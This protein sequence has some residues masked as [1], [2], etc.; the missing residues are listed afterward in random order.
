MTS[1]LKHLKKFNQHSG[2][3]DFTETVDFIL[4]NVSHCIVENDVHYNPEDVT[5]LIIT[6]TIANDQNIELYSARDVSAI[7]YFSDIEIDD[8]SVS[9]SDIDE[10]DGEYLLTKGVHVVKYTFKENVTII[11]DNVFNYNEN[12]TDIKIPNTV[13]SIGEYA[14]GYCEKITSLVIPD[15]VT[16]IDNTSF[17][18]CINLKYINVD[19]NNSIYDSRNNCSAIIETATNELIQGCQNTVIPNTVTSIGDYAFCGIGLTHI[20]IPN[21]VTNIGQYAFGYCEKI[22]SLVIPN[23]VTTIGAYAFTDCDGLISV[24]IPN[25]V[26]TL[27]TNAF[28]DCDKLTSVT[29]DNN[30]IVSKTY[31][32]STSITRTIFGNQVTEYIIGENVTTIGS[33]AFYGSTQ[34]TSVIISS[35]VTTIGNNVFGSCDNLTTVTLNSD[36]IAA[37][38]Y[39]ISANLKKVFGSQVTKYIFGNGVTTIGSYAL[40]GCSNIETVILPNTLTTIDNNAFSECDGLTSITI[41]DSVTTLNHHCFY[42]SG[43]TSI[44][45]PNNITTI[46]TSAFQVCRNLE[47]VTIGSGVQIIDGAAFMGCNSLT[48]ITIPNNVTTI[49]NSAFNTCNG[50]VSLVIGTSVT[51]IGDT[52]FTKC[53]SLVSINSLATTAPT[54]ANGTFSEIASNGTLRVP[55]GSVGY[56]VWMGTG[57]YYLGLYDWTKVES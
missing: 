34:L 20:I 43:L 45:I 5:K 57:N 35:N 21:S 38:T 29:L 2:Y 3:D 9:P 31:T 24:I 13:T 37:E 42:G 51:S 15:S 18:G 33:Y 16:T 7:D 6:Y 8:I 41:P 48:S 40:Y 32:S 12:I 46:P 47:S 53:S 30:A 54:I 25:S 56:D 27:G 52:A 14:F 22:T 23:S 19:K 55:I 26:T 50:L 1:Y 4:P 49:G 36:A 39:S 10:N 17:N 11:D 28:D 44:R